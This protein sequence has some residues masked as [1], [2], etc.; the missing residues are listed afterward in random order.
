MNCDTSV[1][2]RL[3]IRICGKYAENSTRM[4]KEE[5]TYDPGMAPIAEKAL[6]SART[7]ARLDGGRGNELLTQAKRTTQAAYD[8]AMRNLSQAVNVGM[9]CNGSSEVPTE[10]RIAQR[11]SWWMWLL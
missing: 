10:I 2:K 1:P 4:V 11:C 6:V 3:A 7:T 5:D 9:R 8:C